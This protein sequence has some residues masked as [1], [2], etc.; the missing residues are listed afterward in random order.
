[1][2]GFGAPPDEYD[3]LLGPLLTILQTGAAEPEI[4]SCFQKQMNEHFGYSAEE[5]DF[6]ELAGRVRT[7]FERYWSN[8][9]QVTTIMVALL[10][11]GVDVWRPVQARAIGEGLYRILGVDADVKEERWEFPRG[12]VVRC[13]LRKFAEGGVAMTAVEHVAPAG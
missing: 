7:W 3:C 6:L 8:P 9:G 5:R 1:M 12:A 2:T 13:E 11:E 4:A 10:D